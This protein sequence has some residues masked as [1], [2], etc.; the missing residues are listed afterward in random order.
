MLNLFAHMSDYQRLYVRSNFVT[1]MYC[2]KSNS[3][4]VQYFRIPEQTATSRFY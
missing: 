2:T 1:S 4:M 3:M